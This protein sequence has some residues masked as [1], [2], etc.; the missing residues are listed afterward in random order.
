[1]K[2]YIENLQQ[3]KD[4]SLRSPIVGGRNNYER[5]EKL[6]KFYIQ[7]GVFLTNFVTA[8]V[9]DYVSI[10]NRIFYEKILTFTFK[11]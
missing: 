8:L 10:Y 5:V 4:I 6:P 11:E 2:R 1:M 7:G 3:H 9:P